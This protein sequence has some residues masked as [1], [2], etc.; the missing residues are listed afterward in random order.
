MYMYIYKLKIS[1]NY[2]DNDLPKQIKKKTLNFSTHTP[3]EKFTGTIA[4]V[5]RVFGQIKK[6][7]VECR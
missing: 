6:A 3:S 4:H 1:H 5:P 2:R 7:S